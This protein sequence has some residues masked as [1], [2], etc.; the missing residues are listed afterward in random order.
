MKIE[1]F[2][3]LGQVNLSHSDNAYLCQPTG[4]V[5]MENQPGILHDISDSINAMSRLFDAYEQS[6][7][8]GSPVAADKV[9]KWHETLAAMQ[10]Q[11]DDLAQDLEL[12]IEHKSQ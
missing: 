11:I 8:V 3:F 4:E 6:A 12:V 9:R 2:K 7:V 5:L 1:D 10:Q